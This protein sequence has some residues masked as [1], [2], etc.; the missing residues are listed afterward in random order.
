MYYKILPSYGQSLFIQVY[1]MTN[2][3]T[4]LGLIL[5]IL[6]CVTLGGRRRHRI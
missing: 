6:R 2:T 1:D 5:T 3:V 4:L